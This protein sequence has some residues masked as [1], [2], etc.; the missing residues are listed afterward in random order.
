MVQLHCQWNSKLVVY[1]SRS[2]W[3]E[4]NT[5]VAA[6]SIHTNMN[7]EGQPENSHRQALQSA[8]SA[9]GSSAGGGAAAASPMSFSLES[10]TILGLTYV[11]AA[12]AAQ[13]TAMASAGTASGKIQNYS[14]RADMVRTHSDLNQVI[15]IN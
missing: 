2:F 13:F 5:P 7:V 3:R 10:E 12:G 6:F 14:Q 11:S 1:S 9:A 15:V 8:E 4:D